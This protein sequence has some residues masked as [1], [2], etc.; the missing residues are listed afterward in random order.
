MPHKYYKIQDTIIHLNSIR[1]VSLN[2][3]EC[4]IYIS[5]KMGDARTEVF[6]F[7]TEAEATKQFMNLQ[8]ILGVF[9]YV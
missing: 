3:R 4:R 6:C 8:N 2:K 7:S 1:T 5:Y 9:Q